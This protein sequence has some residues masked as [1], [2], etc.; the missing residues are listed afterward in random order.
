MRNLLARKPKITSIILLRHHTILRAKSSNQVLRQIIRCHDKVKYQVNLQQ[1]TSTRRERIS[2]NS[3]SMYI[4]LWR[5]LRYDSKAGFWDPGKTT[6]LG[7]GVRII[8]LKLEGV[9]I[10]DSSGWLTRLN[11][12][13]QIFFGQFLWVSRVKSL[14]GEFVDQNNQNSVDSRKE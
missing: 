3:K 11:F 7:S 4:L 2:K 5:T 1:T 14:H 6:L 8:R 10:I 13:Y 9:W 12:C